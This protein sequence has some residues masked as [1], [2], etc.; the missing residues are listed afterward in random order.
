MGETLEEMEK[1]GRTSFLVELSKRRYGFISVESFKDIPKNKW[2][3][4][5]ISS[6]TTRVPF[7]SIEADA[8]EVMTKFMTKN[9]S[10]LPVTERGEVIGVIEEE[11]LI[12]TF[13][14]LKLEKEASR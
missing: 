5:K 10:L 13:K 3:T 6:L 12:K 9:F 1:E 8:A 4:E 7:I 14:L 2:K 11:K